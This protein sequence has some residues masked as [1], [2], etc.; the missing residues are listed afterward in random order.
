MGLERLR[1]SAKTH[2]G[3]IRE[4]NEDC[5]LAL[6]D[7]GIWLVSDGMGGHEAGDFAS[8]TIVDAVA[9]IPH[10]LGPA[11]RMRW[12]RGAIHRAHDRIRGEAERRGA[13][14]IGATVVVLILTE[15]K[16]VAFW[17]GDSRLYLLR[18]GQLQLLSVDHSAVA[19]LVE[20]G[21]LTW[22]E[23][24]LLPGSNVV[25]RAVGVGDELELSK[26]RGDVAPGDRFLVCSDGLS[27]YFGL[28]ELARVLGSEP[29]E[30]VI[31][32]LIERALGSGGEDNISCIVVDVV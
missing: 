13:G 32:S 11:E 28:A 2:I 6:P 30:T 7:E 14:T 21:L 16:F 4:I 27:R 17:A 29:L 31:E 20:D 5:I 15:T 18:D 24:E 8:Q 22:D 10:G 26:I 19:P 12:V 3:R 1:Y 25:T 9:T 23:A